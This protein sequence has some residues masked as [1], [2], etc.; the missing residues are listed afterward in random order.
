MTASSLPRTGN[1]RW[2]GSDTVLAASAIRSG[3]RGVSRSERDLERFPQLRAAAE[4]ADLQQCLDRLDENLVVGIR[5]VFERGDRPHQ[6]L[7]GGVDL[8]V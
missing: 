1:A 3:G 7:V 2:T 4:V 8:A 5:R 6:H